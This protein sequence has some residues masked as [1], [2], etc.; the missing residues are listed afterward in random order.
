MTPARILYAGTP[1]FAVPALSALITSPYEVS[2]VYTQP[3][4]PAGRGR[5]LEPSPVKRR[6]LEAD[7]AVVQPASLKDPQAQAE[8]AARD[9]DLLVVAAYG[10]ILPQAVLDAPRC[11]CVNIHASLLPRWRGAAPIQRALLAGD[12]ETGISIMRMEAG[13]D[14][15]PVYR[16]A[17]LPITADDTAASLT[18]R[19]AALGA[20]T[21]MAAL[22]GVLDGSAV[23][24]PQDDAAAT[25]ARKI[26]KDEAAI[27]WT[28]PAAAIERAVRAL[29]PWPVAQARLSEEV[30]RIWAA[31]ALPAADA[32]PA[33][34][35]RVLATSAAGIDVGT[36]AGVLRITELQ[37]PGKRRMAARDFLNARR[38][39]GV[40]LG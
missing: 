34:P 32:A 8:L 24:R 6:A 23:P 1:E 16:S 30:L 9:A 18:E 21:L 25:Y 29:N 15:G 22:P 14:T 20:Q 12:A 4:R 31:Q 27:D 38:V 33:E 28:R 7:L 10:L 3:D 19:L 39:D 13:L 37:A 11:G 17:P 2:A 40:L 5:R 26:I 36:G 35:G